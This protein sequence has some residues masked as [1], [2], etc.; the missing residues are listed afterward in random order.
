[1]VPLETHSWRRIHLP[2]HNI[3]QNKISP[4]VQ[5]KYQLQ[6]DSFFFFKNKK[7]IKK[8]KEKKAIIEEASKTA[9][10]A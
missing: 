10:Y 1:M 7:K 8:E 3:N 4:F 2:E 6:K 5:T 9:V